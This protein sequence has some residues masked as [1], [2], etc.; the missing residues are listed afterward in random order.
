MI[1]TIEGTRETPLPTFI[2]VCD[3]IDNYK[4]SKKQGSKMADVERE[5]NSFIAKLYDV[6]YENCLVIN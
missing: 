1:N 2:K 4:Y 5:M 3:G 6:L